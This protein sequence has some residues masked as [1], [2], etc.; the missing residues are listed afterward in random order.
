MN[1]QRAREACV[2][3]RESDGTLA[4][5]P[6]EK[7]SIP[8]TFSGGGGIYSTVPDYL[9]LLQALLNGGSLAGKF[10]LPPETVAL[11]S[12]NQIGN[13]EAGIMKTTNPVLSNDVDFFP[14]ARLRWGLGHMI[15]SD[16]VQAGRKAGSLT[17]A[18]LYN[19][20]YWIDPASGIAGVIMMQIL[21]F[22]DANALELYRQ[23]E[24]EIYRAQQP[25]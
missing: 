24:R 20:Y 5:Q 16:P 9:T 21:P 14:G 12:T 1:S 19:T 17:W 3:V 11:M 6:L 4:P 2:H 8:K 22:A 23:F 18:G 7:R 13:L 15:N 25:A 10:I